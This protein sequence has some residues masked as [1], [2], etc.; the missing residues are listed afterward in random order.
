MWS[1]ISK[2]FTNNKLLLSIACLIIFA[3]LLPYYILGENTHIRVHDNMDSN[4]V[5][6]KLLAESGP[7]FSLSD[8]MLPNAINGLPRSALPSPFDAMVWIYYLFEP[9]TAYTI[10]QTIMRFTAF[11]GMYLLLNNHVFGRLKTDYRLISIGVSL[12]FAL[13]PFWPSGMLSIAGLPLA[14]HILLTIREKKWHSSWYHWMTLLCITFFSNFVLS[15]VFFL[16]LMGLLWI[17]DWFKLRKSN[18]SFFSAIAGMTTVYLVKNYML[19]YSMFFDAGFTS[20]RDALDLGHNSF[21]RTMELALENFLYGHTHDLALQYKVIIP[22]IGL[23]LLISGI[24]NAKAAKLLLSLF[25]FNIALSIWYA[26]WYWEG[27]RVVK[28][29]YMIANTFNFSRIHFLDPMIWYICF[30]IALGIICKNMGWKIGKIFAVVLIIYQCTIAFPLNEENKYS[31]FNTPTFQEF[32]AV[33]LFEE[34]E[35]YIGKKQSSY[36]VVSIGIHPTIAQYNGFYTLDTYNNSFPLK[37]KE[38]FRE[39]IAGELNKSPSLENY[40]DTWGGRLYMYVSEH[41]EDYLFTKERNGAIE[42]LQINVKALRN[43]GG[44]YIFSAV[45]IKNYEELGLEFEKSF[46]TETSAWEIWLYKV[47]GQ[48][49]SKTD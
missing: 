24:R 8:T 3:Y 13:L 26:L 16:G 29:H 18:W 38:Q 27:M 43:M 7:I 41:G 32:Y 47:P 31:Q 23:A 5:W 9:M 37:Y 11:F 44:E 45:P 10:G 49:A 34:I 15:F 42:D 21:D 6:Y 14:L 12:C 4:I 48:S 25:I 33:N 22:V 46:K 28:D 2:N 17:Y 39:I 40:F 1:T 36:R 19:I 35:N 20:H 30:A